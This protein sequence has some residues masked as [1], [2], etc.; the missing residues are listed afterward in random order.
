MVKSYNTG[1]GDGTTDTLAVT[2]PYM[3]KSHV[4]ATVDGVQVDITW[5]TAGQVRVSPA[6]ASGS[7]WVVRRVTPTAPLT[8][9]TP[10]N[11]ST[12]DLNDAERQALFCVEEVQDNYTDLALS[13]VRV[14]ATEVIDPLPPV[15]SR[16]VGM[17]LRSNALGG[18]DMA[19]LTGGEVLFPDVDD[20]LARMRAIRDEA[21]AQLAPPIVRQGIELVHM[22]AMSL[23]RSSDDNGLIELFTGSGKSPQG[24]TYFEIPVGLPLAGP[25]VLLR[26]RVN[27]PD[28]VDELDGEIPE[29]PSVDAGEGF[30]DEDEGD[31]PAEG[32]AQYFR[33]VIYKWDPTLGLDLQNPFIVPTQTIAAG[34]QGCGVKVFPDGKIQVWAPNRTNSD[35]AGRRLGVSVLTVS[36]LAAWITEHNDSNVRNFQL[37]SSAGLG[38]E[39]VENWSEPYFG[40]T[41]LIDKT[42]KQV[43]MI[44]SHIQNRYRSDDV[45]KG[46]TWDYEALAA[47]M[48]AQPTGDIDATH[49]WPINV[50]KVP[51]PEGHDA[52]AKQD[53]DS[54]G[55]FLYFVTGSTMPFGRHV[56]QVVD[57]WGDT[58]VSDRTIDDARG[59]YDPALLYNHPTRGQPSFESEM[60]FLVPD[61]KGSWMF[62][63]GPHE[64]W[65]TRRDVVSQPGVDG[66][67]VNWA[68]RVNGNRLPPGYGRNWDRST[69]PANRGQWNPMTTDYLG[70]GGNTYIRVPLILIKVPEGLPGE[71]P[72]DRAIT[73][74]RSTATLDLARGNKDITVRIGAGLRVDQFGDQ[75]DDYYSF[76]DFR[77]GRFAIYDTYY[78]SDFWMGLTPKPAIMGAYRRRTSYGDRSYYYAGLLDDNAMRIYGQTDSLRANY[79]TIQS[80][81]KVDGSAIYSFYYRPGQ[82]SYVGD[83]AGGLINVKGLQTAIDALQVSVAA[84]GGDPEGIEAVLSGLALVDGSNTDAA[85]FRGNLDV[86]STGTVNAALAEKADV[87]GGNVLGAD[88]AAFRDV[89][90]TAVSRAGL[91]AAQ[92]AAEFATLQ[93]DAN[94]LSVFL[95]NAKTY[96]L[97]SPPT[98]PVTGP[99]KV[100]FSGHTFGGLQPAVDVYR[101][102]IVWT[103]DSYQEQV[104]FPGGTGWNQSVVISVGTGARAATISRSNIIGTGNLI[105]AI[106]ISRVDCMGNTALRYTEY[107]ERSVVHGALAGEFIGI[108]KETAQSIHPF[109]TG[110]AADG[111][112]GP[113]PGDPD[114]DRA[115][116]ETAYPGIGAKIAAWDK[117]VVSSSSDMG[118]NV[119]S[120]RD[121]VNR[122]V[123]CQSSVSSGHRN[124]GSAWAIEYTTASGQDCMHTVM[125][126]KFDTVSGYYALGDTIVSQENAV[127]GRHAGYAAKDANYNALLG[128]YAG[129]GWLALTRCVMVGPSAGGSMTG[130]PVDKKLTGILA[131]NH[132]SG[133]PLIGGD[134]V[135]RKVVIN[136]SPF[137]QT[138]GN[139][140]VIKTDYHTHPTHTTANT[141]VLQGGGIQLKNAAYGLIAFGDAADAEAGA[142]YY[143]HDTDEFTFRTNHENRL[144]INATDVTFN[145]ASILDRLKLDGTNV[146]DNAKTLRAALGAAPAVAGGG[147][148]QVTGSTAKVAIATVALPADP[149]GTLGYLEVSLHAWLNTS[150]SASTKI[151]TV[152]LDGVLLYTGSLGA[153]AA[154]YQMLVLIHAMGAQNVQSVFTPNY[155]SAFA[156][157]ATPH[158]A[159]AVDLSVAKTLVVYAQLSNGADD[160]RVK[161]AVKP[162][163]LA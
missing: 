27:Y 76:I 139:L 14:P 109:Y 47:L 148:A 157:S 21:L 156:G 13:T 96:S 155:T 90:L 153:T 65:K 79:V 160:L 133:D 128:S 73:Q 102:S 60:G 42:G 66:S 136:G 89:A 22:A 106:S 126:T 9:F 122:A 145:G 34:H 11:L 69:A 97:G 116:Y 138:D 18:F 131:I 81:K 134:F 111:S 82:G 7:V 52:D 125:F 140:T 117:Y 98:K 86:P 25:Y 107:L 32:G 5:V 162:N 33:Y 92:D 4:A 114:W 31:E 119:I 3:D 1:V 71:Y 57:M 124:L 36:S 74:Q 12:D 120:G 113:V 29:D 45:R 50:F 154:S 150:P 35:Y 130:A 40:D 78:R 95:Q 161:A 8:V 6:P 110:G 146:G 23:R 144:K 19:Y 123:W 72:L 158:Q 163:Y 83:G 84:L 135:A 143:S 2:F 55:R 141:L 115:G 118:R 41:A 85:A 80:G 142:I 68:N 103:P 51:P 26:Q 151:I 54:D 108:R 53:A 46:F 101:S 91:A 49:L 127:V 17:T 121:A 16:H 88:A 152:E 77:E 64:K 112:A 61:G 28:R 10:G 48:V 137:T 37:L 94:V 30:S 147:Y 70:V 20:A 15:G 100:T 62:C 43:I 44:C 99:G 129:G 159:S 63:V 56:F 58:R 24:G 67:V 38:G 87:D 105:R 93:G 104:G 75:A 39:D 59:T 149:I 132:Q